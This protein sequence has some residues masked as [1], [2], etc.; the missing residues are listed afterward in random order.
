MTSVTIPNSVTTI[1]NEAFYGTA[2][3][4]NQPD[5]LIYA[6]L[7]AYKYK[8]TMPSGTSITLKDG[9]KGIADAAF[10]GCGGLASVTIGNSIETIEGGVF[11]NCTNL[12]NITINA[13]TPPELGGSPFDTSSSN[14]TI[15]VPAESVSAYKAAWS[16]YASK[17]QAIQ[18]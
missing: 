5:G 1:G 3:Y 14:Y 10:Y 8:G 15:Y 12:T 13:T 2:W 9:T 16:S 4:D 11:A 18:E 17:I 7:V 6:G